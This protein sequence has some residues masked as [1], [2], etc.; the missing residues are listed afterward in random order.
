M[1]Q[2]LKP[3]P[4]EPKISFFNM[5]TDTACLLSFRQKSAV[6][7]AAGHPAVDQMGNGVQYPGISLSPQRQ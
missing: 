1:N 4:E 2:G 6:P 7:A 3:V 5:D